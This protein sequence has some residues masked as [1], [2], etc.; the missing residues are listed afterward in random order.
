MPKKINAKR[1]D[2]KKDKTEKI[3]S[4]LSIQQDYNTTLHCLAQSITRLYAQPVAMLIS[5]NVMNN[6]IVQYLYMFYVAY[7]TRM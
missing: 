7:F 6:Y 1:I 4:I 2:A 3:T 5:I